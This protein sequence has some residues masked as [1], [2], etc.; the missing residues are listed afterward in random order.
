MKHI[1]SEGDFL[2]AAGFLQISSKLPSF[3]DIASVLGD[4]A[5]RV[6]G[7]AYSDCQVLTGRSMTREGQRLFGKLRRQ[8]QYTYRDMYTKGDGEAI[9]RN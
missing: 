5:K 7:K 2:R 9:D 6:E 8:L 3:C 1:S 4:T